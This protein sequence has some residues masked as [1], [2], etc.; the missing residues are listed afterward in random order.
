MWRPMLSPAQSSP[1]SQSG[2]PIMLY[3]P[4]NLSFWQGWDSKPWPSVWNNN[5]LKLQLQ[6]AALAHYATLNKPKF[7]Y[8]CEHF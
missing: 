1:L 2:E 8:K 4:V 6:F 7:L 5:K 3:E